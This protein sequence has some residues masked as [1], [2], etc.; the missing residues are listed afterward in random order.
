MEPLA[1]TDA[2]QITTDTPARFRP[3]AALPMTIIF[4]GPAYLILRS[5]VDS[6]S[7]T[8]AVTW[9]AKLRDMK[10]PFFFLMVQDIRDEL[11]RRQT[12]STD[13][14]ASA[15]RHT[16]LKK[17]KGSHLEQLAKHVANEIERRFP[18]L[19]SMTEV[20]FMFARMDYAD[21]S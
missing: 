9:E 10:M 4:L 12:S 11:V 21:V 13:S 6:E 17:M 20:S 18:T 16:S 15:G 19:V 5:A 7:D 3:P 8:H 2:S 1:A 14:I